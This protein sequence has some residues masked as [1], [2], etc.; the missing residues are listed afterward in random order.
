MVR[1]RSSIGSWSPGR[2]RAGPRDLLLSHRGGRLGPGTALATEDAAWRSWLKVDELVGVTVEMFIKI[3]LLQY[4]MSYDVYIYIY[5]Y[6]C[7]CV[8]IIS[9][10]LDFLGLHLDVQGPWM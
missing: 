6:L 1:T 7:V 10:Y 5:I 4:M 9:V 2:S 8:P 3:L